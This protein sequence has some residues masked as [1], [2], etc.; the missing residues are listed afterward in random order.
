MTKAIFE[1]LSEVA[2]AKTREEK[3]DILKSNDDMVLRDI[4]R[5][6]FDEAI[7]WKLPSGP[8][9]EEVVEPKGDKMDLYAAAKDLRFFVVGGPGHKLPA[10]QRE[11]RFF[12]MLSKIHP[13]DAEI[14]VLMKDKKLTGK[15][16]GLTKKLIQDTWP[17]LIVR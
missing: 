16:K 13:K 10:V 9:P 4:L 14:I 11:K 7:I 2:E 15:Y 5:G 17:N 8:I 1:I 12:D 3:R 6:A